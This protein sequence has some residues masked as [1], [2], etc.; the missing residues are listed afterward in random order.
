LN[1]HAEENVPM[2]VMDRD[3]YKNRKENQIN[4]KKRVWVLGDEIGRNVRDN[5]KKNNIHKPNN[6]ARRSD[7][8]LEGATATISTQSETVSSASY[9]KL[10]NP[11]PPPPETPLASIPGDSY[12]IPYIS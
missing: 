9:E 4:T 6:T 1:I 3:K 5:R 12:L 2:A 8:E 7:P 11:C 10:N